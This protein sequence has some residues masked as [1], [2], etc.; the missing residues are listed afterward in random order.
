[1]LTPL[2]PP[3][4][5]DAWDRCLLGFIAL[6]SLPVLGRLACEVWRAWLGAGA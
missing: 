5:M 3:P 4:R 2:E 1:M 6:S